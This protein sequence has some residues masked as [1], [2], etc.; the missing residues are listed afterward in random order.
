MSAPDFKQPMTKAE[1]DNLGEWFGDFL[2][3][4]VQNLVDTYLIA[5]SLVTRDG[6]DT[7]VSTRSGT[8]IK[9]TVEV[10]K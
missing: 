9:F 8:V 3:E 10:Q 6:N 1:S 7:T 5:P 4:I 2:N